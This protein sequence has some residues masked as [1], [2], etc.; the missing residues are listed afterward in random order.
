MSSVSVSELKARLSHYLREVRQGGE[1]Q[2]LDR[3]NLVARIVPPAESGNEHRER[4]IS[5]GLLRRGRGNPAMILDKEPL[6]LPVSISDALEEDQ[7]D[8]L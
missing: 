4:L 5:S 7:E 6:N 2:V 3:G 8:R 1:I